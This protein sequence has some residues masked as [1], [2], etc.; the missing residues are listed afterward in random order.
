MRHLITAL[1][2][3]TTSLAVGLYAAL[4]RRRQ[5]RI[6]VGAFVRLLFL[7]PVALFLEE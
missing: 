2:L 7:W 3:L 5:G 1:L 6:G 4:D